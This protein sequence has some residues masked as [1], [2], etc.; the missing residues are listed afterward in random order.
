[1]F[2]EGSSD[3]E[4]EFWGRDCGIFVEEGEDDVDEENDEEVE[5]DPAV[6]KDGGG[7]DLG[8]WVERG[9]HVVTVDQGEEAFRG[10]HEALELE[11]VGAW[12]NFTCMIRRINKVKSF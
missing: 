8:D 10:W 3:G 5:V 7:R 11:M 9:E 2:A 6:D 12:T 4:I 1:M